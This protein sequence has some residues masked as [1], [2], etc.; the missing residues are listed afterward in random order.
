MKCTNQL[1]MRATLR[2]LSTRAI[3]QAN[4]LGSENRFPPGLS[5]DRLGWLAVFR[6][7]FGE[8]QVLEAS[9]LFETWGRPA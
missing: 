9:T 1:K 6:M 3:R 4:L 5:F 8:V 7:S 2:P